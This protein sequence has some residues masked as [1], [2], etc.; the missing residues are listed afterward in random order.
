MPDMCLTPSYPSPDK[1]PGRR[2]ALDKVPSKQSIAEVS[3]TPTEVPLKVARKV[4]LS[5]AE[6]EELLQQEISACASLH[7]GTPTKQTIGTLQH[8]LMCPQPPFAMAHDATPLL[9]KYATQGCPVGCGRD[10]LHK[11]QL[12]ML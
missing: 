2:V 9:Q 5:P 10:W 12:L 6:E 11:H 8:G 7:T 1:V 4:A 3:G